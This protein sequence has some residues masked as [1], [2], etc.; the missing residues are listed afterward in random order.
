MSELTAH[1]ITSYSLRNAVLILHRA[2]DYEWTLQKVI[3]EIS[4]KLDVAGITITENWNEVLV[5]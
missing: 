1:Y 3:S 4:E 5:E 2:A